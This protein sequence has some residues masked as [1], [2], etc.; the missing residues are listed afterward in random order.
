M[1]FLLT[2][3]ETAPRVV[4]IDDCVLPPSAV[5]AKY[6]NNLKAAADAVKGG[7]LDLTFKNEAQKLFDINKDLVD[8]YRLTTICM[9]TKGLPAERRTTLISQVNSIA[10]EVT[11][12]SIAQ[13]TSIRTLVIE[14]LKTS[15]DLLSTINLELRSLAA[16]ASAAV[17][18]PEENLRAAVFMM[19]KDG[20]LR[21]PKNFSVRMFDAIEVTITLSPGVGLSGV[22][23]QSNGRVI[24]MVRRKEAFF[25]DGGRPFPVPPGGYKPFI[26]PREEEVKIARELE[27]IF[28][29]PMKI[30][31]SFGEI[32]GVLSLDCVGKGCEKV[33]LDDLAQLLERDMITS[34]AR[35]AAILQ[36]QFKPDLKSAK[37]T[38]A[39]GNL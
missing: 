23:Y 27:W 30:D 12:V 13:S 25:V 34:A 31:S 11:K 19:S 16:S 22:A 35:M 1:G 2:A 14:D 4:V 17:R 36:S 5:G 39:P 15:P 33:K 38:N 37:L 8:L 9:V 3:C 29:A 28:S 7:S 18:V 24:G 26:L 20:R 10:Q 32:V 21:V 6:E